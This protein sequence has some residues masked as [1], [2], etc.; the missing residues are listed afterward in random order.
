MVAAREAGVIDQIE[1]LSVATTP[2]DPNQDIAAANPTGKIPTMVLSDGRVV[3][4]SRVICE[5]IETLNTGIKLYPSHPDSLLAAQ[6]LHALGDAIMDAGVG[7]R[8]ELVVRPQDL[9]WDRWVKGQKVKI[10]ASLDYLE[11]QCLEV[12]NGPITIGHVAIACAL[13]YIEFRGVVTDWRTGHD[14]LA[15]WAARFSERDSM[16]ATVPS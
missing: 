13:D 3:F 10:T 7:T 11:D 2:V 9:Q 16:K 1:I 4:D 12:L 8:Y 6:T 15:D 14:G 5:Y